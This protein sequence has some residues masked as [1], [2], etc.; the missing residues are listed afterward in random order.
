MVFAAGAPVKPES[1]VELDLAANHLSVLQTATNTD[2]DAGYISQPEAVEF[3]TDNDLTAHAFYYAPTNRDYAPP[4]G[5]KPPLLVTCHGGPTGAATMDLDLWT[6]YWTSRGIAV[7]DVNY[8]GSTGYGRDYRERLMGEWGVVDV[9][10]SI[11]GARFLVARGD[12]DENRLAIS[13]ESAGGYTALA[14]LTF[15]DVFKAG[16]SHFGVSDLEALLDGIHKFDTHSLHALIG[17]YPLYRKKYVERSPINYAEQL[18]SPVIFFQGLEDTIVP[19]DQSKMMFDVLR[20]KGVP[21]AYITFEGEEH[22]FV[23]SENI[24][25]A[26]EAELYFYSRV[27]GFDVA[28][29][30]A[31]VAIYNL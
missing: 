2:I 4:P 19:A 29:R 7:L 5:D 21:T 12:V 24:K 8:G 6:Q 9:N 26:L 10:D 11:N 14:A 1:V 30:I 13:G 3:P 17:P 16:A 31:P 22:G 18:S 27:F 28:D 23:R 20:E 15:R 25:R